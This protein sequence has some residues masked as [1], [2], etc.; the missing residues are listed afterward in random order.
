VGYARRSIA[1]V[2]CSSGCG[3]DPPSASG[4]ISGA[5]LGGAVSDC[6]CLIAA[7]AE[8]ALVFSLVVSAQG[9]DNELVINSCTT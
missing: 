5:L 1:N 3:A 7:D 9:A 6:H 8:I 4:T 2:L